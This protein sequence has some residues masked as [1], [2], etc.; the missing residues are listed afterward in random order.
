M[1]SIRGYVLHLLAA[2][3]VSGA[4]M[5]LLRGSGAVCA[6]AKLLCG[7]FLIYC[8]VKP[9]SQLDMIDLGIVG[10][11]LQTQA[12]EAAS[13]GEKE[14]RAAFA[15]SITQQTQTYILEKA[16]EMNVDLVVQ[17]EVSEDDIPMP[18]SV[19]ITGKISPY[20]KTRLSDLI[21]R[22]LG[23]GKENQIWT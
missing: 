1:E 4:V 3:I 13:W 10:T 12:E 9:V 15:E 2:A 23:I 19:C 16:K 21:T 6:I 11:Q 17:V 20:A 8:A 18:E 22:E 14:A 7:I 5:R